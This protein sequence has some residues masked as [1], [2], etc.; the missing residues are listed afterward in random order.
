M[1]PVPEVSNPAETAR[2]HVNRHRPH[3]GRDQLTP[4]HAPNVIPLPA[5]RIQ[6]RKAVAGLIEERRPVS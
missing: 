3:E 5:A 4:L 6:R 2:Q 1:Q